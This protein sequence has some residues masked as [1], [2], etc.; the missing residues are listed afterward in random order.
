M[1]NN[2]KHE[3]RV[4]CCSVVKAIGHGISTASLSVFMGPEL[5]KHWQQAVGYSEKNTPVYM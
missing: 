2:G 3:K 5:F 4:R 1:M